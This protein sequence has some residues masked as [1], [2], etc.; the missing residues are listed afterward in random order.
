MPNNKDLVDRGNL[1]CGGPKKVAK[2][3]L[4]IETPNIKLDKEITCTWL[5]LKL[6][7]QRGNFKLLNYLQGA[8]PW[9]GLYVTCHRG[10]LLWAYFD[11]LD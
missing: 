7:I 10:T 6:M 9:G 3:S 5:S 2:T 4:K 8:T 1:H 11:G